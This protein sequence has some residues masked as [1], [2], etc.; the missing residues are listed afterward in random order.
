MS[1]QVGIIG[2]GS[3]ATALA[4]LFL[5]NCPA[6]SW[7]LRNEED[8]AYF[9]EY[10]NN[11]RYLTSVEFETENIRFHTDLRTIVQEAQYLVLAI[12]SAFLHKTLSNL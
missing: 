11:P 7:Y 5:N 2:S 12:P 9:K 4:K 1:T 3:W 6:I 10:K 8:V